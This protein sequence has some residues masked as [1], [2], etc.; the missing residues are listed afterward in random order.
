MKYG[1][2]RYDTAEVE[3]GLLI[4]GF[5]GNRTSCIAKE[6]A[7]VVSRPQHTFYQT[8]EKALGTRL[9]LYCMV[10]KSRPATGMS[11]Q[12]LSLFTRPQQVVI[13]FATSCSFYRITLRK[14]LLTT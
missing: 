14:L 7:Q 11:L 9:T 5:Y 6:I 12:A 8:K 2:F 3:N 4:P 1:T 10:V 13:M